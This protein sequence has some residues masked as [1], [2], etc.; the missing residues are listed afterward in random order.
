MQHAL[1]EVADTASSAVVPRASGVLPEMAGYEETK[2]QMLP[3]NT[4]FDIRHSRPSSR[5]SAGSRRSHSVSPVGLTIVQRQAQLVAQMASTAASDVGRV[6]AAAD[7]TRNVAEQAL[8]TASHAAGLIEGILCEHIQRLH[9]DKSRVVDDVA[10]CLA[11]ELMIAAAG[12][13]N[14]ANCALVDW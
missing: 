14:R 9:V 4:A 12:L 10:H 13:S 6:A 11:T 8:A 3:P 5:S 2:M 1:L 7:A